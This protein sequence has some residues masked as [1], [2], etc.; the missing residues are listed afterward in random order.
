MSNQPEVEAKKEIS[1]SGWLRNLLLK[2]H[3]LTFEQFQKE[4][5]AAWPDKACS[6]DRNAVHLKRTDLRKRWGVSEMS[7][8]PALKKDGEI[9]ASGML[10]LYFQNHGTDSP[11]KKVI[12][13]HKADGILVSPSLYSYA[14]RM[15]RK[16][17]SP[18]KNQNAGPRAGFSKRHRSKSAKAK[19]MSLFEGMS[20]EELE[21]VIVVK[22]AIESVGGI[23]NFK[24]A[25][26][27]VG[28]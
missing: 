3:D 26:A 25:F 16:K 18:D 20:I 24:S 8:F 19:K 13:F 12:E 5:A 10:Q 17:S 15:F 14:L 2:N 22:K 27:L 21:H 28:K 7:E 9:N 6:E 11:M 23:E 1:Y 4:H